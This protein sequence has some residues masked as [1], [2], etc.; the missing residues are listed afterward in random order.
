MRYVT[1]QV[2]LTDF[3]WYRRRLIVDI[4]GHDHYYEFTT[5]EFCRDDVSLIT[6]WDSHALGVCN[7]GSMEA[8]ILLFDFK[9]MTIR[10]VSTWCMREFW[11]H[12]ALSIGRVALMP[13][14]SCSISASRKQILMIGPPLSPNMMPSTRILDIELEHYTQVCIIEYIITK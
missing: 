3:D 2:V 10:E 1:S 13:D 11:G 14:F 8:V 5:S 7:M 6:V 4:L 9:S 12:N